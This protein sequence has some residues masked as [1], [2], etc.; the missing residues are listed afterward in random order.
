[1]KTNL[2][3]KSFINRQYSNGLIPSRILPK[4]A[5][6]KNVT[7]DDTLNWIHLLITER[8]EASIGGRRIC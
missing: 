3:Q 8:G 5:K 6:R 4:K 7:S 2:Q 1:M